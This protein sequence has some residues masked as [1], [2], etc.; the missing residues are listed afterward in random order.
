M[1]TLIIYGCFTRGV[2]NILI[3]TELIVNRVYAKY[4]L[5][6]AWAKQDR[7]THLWAD[8]LLYRQANS[9]VGFSAWPKCCVFPLLVMATLQRNTKKFLHFG[10]DMIQLGWP[11]PYAMSVLKAAAKFSISNR[12]IKRS[13]IAVTWEFSNAW[14]NI[15][16]PIQYE[17]LLPTF[18]TFACYAAS[19]GR[20]N[21]FKQCMDGMLMHRRKKGRWYPRAS[22]SSTRIGRIFI[23]SCLFTQVFSPCVKKTIY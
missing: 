8:T 19:H 13:R 5:L 10:R 23:E 6:L 21:Y 7:T 14:G 16:G 2:I 1:H 9:P 12:T 20:Q 18:W 17:F 4:L 11:Y 22:S 15:I 3:L